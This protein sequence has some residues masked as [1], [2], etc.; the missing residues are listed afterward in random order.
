MDAAAGASVEFEAKRPIMDNPNRQIFKTD[1]NLDVTI[2]CGPTSR[3]REIAFECKF[4]EPYRLSEP[5]KN[6]L[7]WP[8]IREKQLWDGLPAC[9]ELGRKLSPGDNHFKHLHAAQLLRHILGLKHRNGKT[10]FCL[11]YLWYDV[12]GAS[13]ADRHRCEISEFQEIVMTDGI[14]LHAVTFQDVISTLAQQRLGHE[15]Y[16]D[17]LVNRYL[18]A[19]PN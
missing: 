19:L 4:T 11:V 14:A 13:E 7:K 9:L 1:P 17:Y 18:Q 5:A 3:S 8:Y 16:V 10:G 6:G 12:P 15:Q 2:R